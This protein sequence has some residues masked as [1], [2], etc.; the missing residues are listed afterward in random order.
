MALG[1]SSGEADLLSG[2]SRISL[3]GN[4]N[5]DVQ[6]EGG[7]CNDASGCR[8]T[9]FT[10]GK[11]IA[12]EAPP[13]AGRVITKWQLVDGQQRWFGPQMSLA[14]EVVDCGSDAGLPE[15]DVQPV[16]DGDLPVDDSGADVDGSDGAGVEDGSEER[17]RLD[18]A[19]ESEG[20]ACRVTAGVYSH[21]AYVGFWVC[22]MLIWIRRRGRNRDLP[23]EPIAKLFRQS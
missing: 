5:S 21:G 8:R 16:G 23:V 18:Y 20:C 4:E 7:F 2:V 9:R 15:D 11:G 22:G 13:S 14:F 12:A 10:G 1:A 19:D 6:S 3:A 17:G